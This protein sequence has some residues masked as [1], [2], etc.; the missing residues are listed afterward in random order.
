MSTLL[1][2]STERMGPRQRVI[3]K[4]RCI[5]FGVL[6]ARKQGRVTYIWVLSSEIGGLLKTGKASWLAINLA[7]ARTHYSL[8]ISDD[9]GVGVAIKSF[10]ESECCLL[11]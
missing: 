1:C 11:M 4:E 10:F 6:C 8:R 5:L 9:L 2:A 7:I 3:P